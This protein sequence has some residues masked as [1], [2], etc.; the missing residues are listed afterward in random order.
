[1]GAGYVIECTNRFCKYKKHLF[2]GLGMRF[3]AVYEEVMAKARN[4]EFSE[5]HR[6]KDCFC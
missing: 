5:E 4:G 2:A 3:P 6:W 1:M